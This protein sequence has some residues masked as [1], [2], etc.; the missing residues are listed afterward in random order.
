MVSRP[1][2]KRA[3]RP[4]FESEHCQIFFRTGFFQGDIVDEK[5]LTERRAP[6][7][8]SQELRSE[9]EYLT[10]CVQMYTYSVHLCLNVRKAFARTHLHS[11]I[12]ISFY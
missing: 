2:G 5:Q 7:Q 11:V 8:S 3:K 10:L 9:N 4:E 12:N 1:K 6:N